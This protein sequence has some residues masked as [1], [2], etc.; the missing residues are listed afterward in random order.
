MRAGGSGE[1]E[2][3]SRRVR[4]IALSPTMAIA[5]RAAALREA[6]RDVVSLALGE[7]DFATPGHAIA[8]AHAAA[9]RGLTRY[10][11][12]DGADAVKDA[13]VRKLARDNRLAY[14]RSEIHV[15][16]GSKQVIHNALAAT[17][18]PGDEVVV[19]APCWVSYADIVAFCGGTA[20][21]VPAAMDDGFMPDPAHVARALSG[22]TR[23]IIVN[24]PN[25]PTGA[26]YPGGLLRDL[27]A[28]V[29][30]HPGAMILSDEIYEHMVFDG[31]V[32][33]SILN[34]A[35]ALRERTLVVNGVSKT[36]AM[37]GW[38][39]GF[40]AGPAW[41]VAAMAAVQSQT[42]GNAASISQAAAAAAMDGGQELLPRR[43]ATMQA[44]RDLACDVLG[45]SRRLRAFRP[46]GAFYV[47]V[48]VRDCL[49]R[50]GGGAAVGT[51][52]D[53]AER[54]LETVGVATVPGAA[55]GASPYLRLSLAAD[56]DTLR[57]ACERIV[58]CCDAL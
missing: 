9:L 38:R 26:V 15:A 39:I 25:N 10:T 51:D 18:D 30:A 50:G 49:G 41:L 17:L 3:L 11:P 48:D 56:E 52:V 22:R 19:V 40:G 2:R 13:V 45:R 4:R 27:A 1:A 24:S 55:F 54:I 23:W 46:Q 43:C 32:H 31:L 42:A 34:V 44:R 16:S 6:G 36:Y 35:P 21:A 57:D 8:A 20:V 53:L 28:A 14:G 37:T 47:F 7:P 58:S 29:A 33:R 12:P 5:Q